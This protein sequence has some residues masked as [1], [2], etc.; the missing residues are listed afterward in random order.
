MRRQN[1]GQDQRK[2]NSIAMIQNPTVR[3]A[4]RI[5]SHMRVMMPSQWRL[6][7][8]SRHHS[9]SSACLFIVGHLIQLSIS[10]PT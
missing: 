8:C 6:S 9:A 3:L 4:A 10:A 1:Q 2:N 7:A 5:V